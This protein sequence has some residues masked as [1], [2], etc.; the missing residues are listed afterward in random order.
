MSADSQENEPFGPDGMVN[1]RAAPC[2][3]L[4]RQPPPL[5][6]LG[7]R[8]PRRHGLQRGSQRRP[9]PA[10]LRH[11]AAEREGV[12]ARR[13]CA[14]LQLLH[15]QDGWRVRQGLHGVPPGEMAQ[16]RRRPTRYEPT[17]GP[18]GC[19]GCGPTWTP[20]TEAPGYWMLALFFR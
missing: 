16:R 17:A 7:H 6:R 20:K 15:G 14:H 11:R 8:P 18:E 9:R 1:S 4:G 2:S 19:G 13:Q 10:V 5:P 3:W 12:D